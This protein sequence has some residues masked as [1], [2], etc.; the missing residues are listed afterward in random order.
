ML[1]I[2]VETTALRAKVGLED[3]SQD[4]L[5][6]AIAAEQIPAIEATLVGAYG[7]EVDLGVS[8]IVA[9][10]YLDTVARAGG[11]LQ[12][13]ELRVGAAESSAALRARGEARLA[14]YRRDAGVV[15]AAGPR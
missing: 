8:E 12:I 13:G 2:A 7:P 10:E 15:R 3:D 6:E 14:P 11:E 9:A 5:L 1:N 4:A